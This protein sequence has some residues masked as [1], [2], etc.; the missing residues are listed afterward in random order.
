MCVSCRVEQHVVLG[1]RKVIWSVSDHRDPTHGSELAELVFRAQYLSGLIHYSKY[2]IFFLE[3]YPKVLHDL[4]CNIR[5]EV[6]LVG[7]P[8][9]ILA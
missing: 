8:I 5:S 7:K 3:K 9:R 6:L 2:L 4:T 1:S